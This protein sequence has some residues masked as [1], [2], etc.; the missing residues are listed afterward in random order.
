MKATLPP[1]TA[2]FRNHGVDGV[3]F[4]RARL[5]AMSFLRTTVVVEPWAPAGAAAPMSA[6]ST[7]AATTEAA[8]T[9]RRM[10]MP[11]C[12]PSWPAGHTAEARAR[13]DPWT[14]VV[15]VERA[16]LRAHQGTSPPTRLRDPWRGCRTWAHL[17]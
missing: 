15:R 13:A 7:D 2:A 11:A 3:D 6:S 1:D 4:A 5:A 10:C 9:D 8:A 17:T 16:V 14:G 12:F